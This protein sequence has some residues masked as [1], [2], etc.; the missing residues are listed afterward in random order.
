MS[1]EKRRS[2]LQVLVSLMKKLPVLLGKEV[3]NNKKVGVVAP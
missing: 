3:I 1:K 2:S